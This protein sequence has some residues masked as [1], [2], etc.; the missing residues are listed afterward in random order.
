MI[1]V[2]PTALSVGLGHVFACLRFSVIAIAWAMIN[3][4]FGVNPDL[5]LARRLP[6]RGRCGGW[7]LTRSGAGWRLW[8]G[9]LRENCDRDKEGGQRRQGQNKSQYLG[10]GKDYRG[11]QTWA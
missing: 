8:A 6:G 10:S 9:G 7:S 3:L 2:E 1:R 5:S 11:M 4:G